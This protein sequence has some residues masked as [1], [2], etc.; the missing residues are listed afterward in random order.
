MN[1]L[2]KIVSEQASAD[3]R[4]MIEEGNDDLLAAIH[5][6]ESEAQLQETSPKFNIGFKI[7][8]DLDKSVFD[9][10]LSWTLKQSLSTSHAIEDPNQ[11]PLPSEAFDDSKIIIRTGDKTV[12]KTLGGM[13]KM[14]GK[15]GKN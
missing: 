3:L 9:C 13:K 7:S 12:E 6:M 2:L 1:A 10:D 14:N 15:Q 5:K 11:M 4:K 8:I